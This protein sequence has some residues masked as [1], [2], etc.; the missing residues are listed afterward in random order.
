MLLHVYIYMYIYVREALASYMALLASVSQR[1][2]VEHEI[3]SFT[4]LCIIRLNRFIY[5]NWSHFHC[6]VP[7]DTKQIFRK[8]ALY[9]YTEKLC[10]SKIRIVVT[11]LSIRCARL[12]TP[13]S[14]ARGAS[15]FTS[16]ENENRFQCVTLR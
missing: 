2:S 5:S 11:K 3:S 12:G 8:V 4:L 14:D 13:C 1:T 9:L 6:T 10:I 16:H 15:S 7:C